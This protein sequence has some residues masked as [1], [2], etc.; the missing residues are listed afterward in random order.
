MFFDFVLFSEEFVNFKCMQIAEF[1]PIIENHT[2]SITQNRVH[3]KKKK[4]INHII[5]QNQK[6]FASLVT[7]NKWRGVIHRSR[8]K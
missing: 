3:K 7:Q 5:L 4:K 1:R 6:F 8:V 2:T